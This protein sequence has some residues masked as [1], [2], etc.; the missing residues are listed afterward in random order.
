MS[1]GWH[2]VG[3]YAYNH[4]M[5]ETPTPARDTFAPTLTVVLITTTTHAEPAHLSL[6]TTFPEARRTFVVAARALHREAVEYD[7]PEDVSFEVA[8]DRI[9]GLGYSVK[10]EDMPV[11]LS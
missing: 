6:H 11:T 10:V 7:L 8:R 3:T 4:G 1:G 2:P 5:T 9:T